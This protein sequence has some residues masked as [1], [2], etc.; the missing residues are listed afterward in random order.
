MKNHPP[1]PLQLFISLLRES[2]AQPATNLW[3][4][5]E[6]TV[7]MN[8]ALPRLRDGRNI[9]DLGCGDGGVM[10]LLKP[11]FSPDAKITGLDADAEETA[12]AKTRGVYAEVLSSGAEKMPIADASMDAIVSNSVLEHI[13]PLEAVLGEAGRVLRSGGWF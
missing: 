9:L 5:H 10:A 11:C 8:H 12:L 7:L 13:D 1:F 4:A 6:L 2:P 3:R